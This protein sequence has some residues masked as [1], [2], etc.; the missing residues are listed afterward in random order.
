MDQRQSCRKVN[1][2]FAALFLGLNPTITSI[3]LIHLLKRLPELLDPKK[4]M[5]CFL[6]S[7]VYGQAV[8]LAVIDGND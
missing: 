6:F 1:A 8:G 4:E 3:P 2:N 5:R 7:Q